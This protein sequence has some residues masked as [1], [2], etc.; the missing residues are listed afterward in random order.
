MKRNRYIYFIF[1]LVV[2]GLGLLSRKLNNLPIFISTYLGDVLWALMVFLVIAFIFNKKSTIFIA[3]CSIVFSYGIELSQLYHSPWIDN[4]RS[5]I[6]GG[7]VLGFGF[8]WSDI[9]CYTVGI[10]MGMILDK[11]ML[12]SK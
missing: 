3:V 12:S 2:M 1:T 5:T 11:Y 4:I 10:L 6:L 9:L 7:L 8:L